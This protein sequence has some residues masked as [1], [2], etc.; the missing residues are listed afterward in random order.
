[1]KEKFPIYLDYNATTPLD[2]EVS[3]VMIPYLKDFFGN[4]SS[5]H[6]YGI[7]TKN[8]IEN[9]RQ[10]VAELLNCNPYEI[11]FTSGGTE[12]NN[13][14]LKGVAYANSHKGKHIITSSVEHPAIIEVCRSLGE[15]G[16]DITYLPVDEYGRVNPK[17]VEKSIR[18]QTILIT[19]MHA[20]NEVG[21]I[22][23][24]K[25]IAQ[26]A[27]NHNILMHTDAAQSV[28]KIETDVNKLGV[29]LLS[30]AGH[31]LY[32][33]KGIGVLYV[34]KGV[35]LKKIMHGADHEQN[36][37]PGTENV[38][39]IV[40]LGKACEVARLNFNENYNYVLDL[41]IRF[42]E[43][44]LKV[45]PKLRING[46]KEFCL[47]NT[48]SVGFR[49]IEANTLLMETDEIAASAGAACHTDSD[50]DSSVLKAMK[51][52]DEYAMGT[53]RFSLGKYNT[54][55]EINKAVEVIYGAVKKFSGDEILTELDELNDIK[56]T[57]FTHG[58][59]C[60]CKLNPQSLEEVLK[61]LSTPVNEN[62]LV[63]MS[64]SDDAAVYKI[65]S[66]TA[67][68]QTVDFFT[69][70]V[71]DPFHFGAISAA[72]SLSDIYA[73]GATPIY[74][75]NIIGFPLNRLPLEVM[76]QILK[77]AES[78]AK[79]AGID[80]L[81]G[82]SIEDIEP[83]YGM[84]VTG[85]VHPDKILT[86][87]NAKPGDVLVL[88]KPLGTGILSTAMKRGLLSND[89]KETLIATMSELN[90]LNL[91]DLADIHINAC[92]D[93]TGFG[94]SG[95][96]LEMVR[97]SGVEAE[98][99]LNEIEIMDTVLE[100]I[101]ANIIPGGSKNN[102]SYVDSGIIWDDDI[103]YQDK[104]LISDAQTSG[105]LLLSLP[106]ED[107]LIFIDKINKNRKLK[108]VIIGEINSYT[109]GKIHVK[110][111]RPT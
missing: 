48:I 56:L 11:I 81:G 101:A 49:G 99:W 110:R 18:K 45:L 88:T 50:E 98:L 31:K 13:F 60:A 87:S 100:L 67:I 6:K 34:R 27:K 10:Q 21:T 46:H 106:E 76:K 54:N 84:A 2:H 43:R 17:D 58:L 29:D 14:A 44:L 109:E 83:K 37:R 95:H 19:V 32:G 22:Q 28:G 1:M 90:K 59:G 89:A 39:E 104:I 64:T 53:I 38:L 15:S 9:G 47:P 79:E 93:V 97:S 55:D 66:E 4:P 85:I 80:V 36:M 30:L 91:D 3:E 105:G 8:A 26:I 78:K 69:P 74:A 20:N 24:I 52:P 62:I 63:G 108:S 102:L 65:N 103:T 57:H 73:M 82:H 94:L 107:A 7:Q 25:E 71:D 77:G 16:F 96:L 42:T 111:N 75:L 68:V 92:T 51:V 70:I 41:K 5:N 72:N 23:P 12:S 35:Q 33:P 61:E 40:G 86:N